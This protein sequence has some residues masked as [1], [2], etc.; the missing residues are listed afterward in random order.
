MIIKTRI[1][2]L[3]GLLILPITIAGCAAFGLENKQGPKAEPIN[4]ADWPTPPPTP[5]RNTPT[6]FVQI[7]LAP[8][9]TPTPQPAVTPTATAVSGA[10]EADNSLGDIEVSGNN[11]EAV[12]QQLGSSLVEKYPPV[13]IALV[14]SDGTTVRQGPGSSFAALGTLQQGE[15]AGIIGTDASKSWVYILS[16][17]L[18][19]GWVTLDDIRATGRLSDAPVLPND[20]VPAVLAELLSSKAD[21][22]DTNASADSAGSSASSSSS[23]PEV[24]PTAASGPANVPHEASAVLNSLGPVASAHINH[25]DV[26]I[27][28]HPSTDYAAIDDLTDEQE[29]ISV[30]A[31]DPTRQWALVQ[32]EF[33]ELGWV[34][35]DDLTVEGSLNSAPEVM[36]A[37]VESNGIKV[38]DG[39]GIYNNV[40]GDL[41]INTLVQLLG[42]GDNRSW[43]LVK[44]LFSENAGWAQLRFLKVAGRLAD[45]PQAPDL[46]PAPV[47]TAQV[48]APEP[49]TPPRSIAESKIVFQ[50]SS[51]GDIMVINPDGTGLRKLT[52]GI[53]PVLSPDGQ[54]VAFTRWEGE[55]GSLWVVGIDGT[56]ERQILDYTKQA[57]GPDWSP[58]GSKI[59]INFQQGGQLEERRVCTTPDG[60]TPN[61]PRNAGNIRFGFD[62]KGEAKLCWTTPP[63]PFWQ[64]RVVDVGSGEF[65]DFDGGTYAFRP[66]W[67]PTRSWRLISDGGLGLVEVDVNQNIQKN[68][69]EEVG[70]GS[71]IFS[72]DGR[73]IAVTV[74]RQGGS[75]N[76]NIQRL[77]ADGSGRV[78]LTQTPL[79][80]TTG[81]DEQPAWNNVA[82]AWSPDSSQ[83]AFLTDRT[84]RWEIWVMNVDGS[85]PHPLFSDEVND[86]LQITYDFVDE[87]VLSWK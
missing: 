14:I 28:P 22:T 52:N 85:N 49:I 82:P 73:F 16:A 11:L 72:P 87:R 69:T 54:S 24:Q 31:V 36:T 30:L 70:D 45:L 4:V 67:D 51:G 18:F 35:L 59:A 29:A 56:N 21:S 79:W 71:P 23:A 9:A 76:Y 32:P 77:N 53:D 65:K 13:A 61:I 42:V 84:G 58:D 37:W 19:R 1:W 74:G 2:V 55:T 41:S 3:F 20:P 78:Q 26:E 62:N 25:L 75:Q 7:T 15:L 63:N 12:A 68:I 33:S 34:S 10:A 47:D 44:P 43:A 57:K 60:S 66:A 27:R 86:Q 17:E 39:P 5:E 46:P 6:P 50:R 81:P 80:V 40:V 8:T 64:L 38:Y 83:I 48:A